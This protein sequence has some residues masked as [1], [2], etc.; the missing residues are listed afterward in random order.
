M[1]PVSV[2]E[3]FHRPNRVSKGLSEILSVGLS[4]LYHKPT[5]M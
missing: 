3:V 4:I 2:A 5:T 1:Y